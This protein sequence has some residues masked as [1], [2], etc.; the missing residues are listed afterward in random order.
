MQKWEKFGLSGIRVDLE[1]I[2]GLIEE[3]GSNGVENEAYLRGVGGASDVGIDLALV[4][5]LVGAEELLSDEFQSPLVVESASVL[6][7]A[8]GDVNALH[9]LPEDIVLV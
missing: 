6:R 8:A 2:H 4:R 9:L 5:V 3:D 1:P 7:E